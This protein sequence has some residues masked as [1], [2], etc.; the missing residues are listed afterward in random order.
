[1]EAR[2]SSTNRLAQLFQLHLAAGVDQ[3]E[4]GL[5]NATPTAHFRGNDES[6]WSLIGQAFEDL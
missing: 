2:V 4:P 5:D 3:S 6:Q 1:M